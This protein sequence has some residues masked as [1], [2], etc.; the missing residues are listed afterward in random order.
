MNFLA[1][2]Y[3]SQSISFVFRLR[4][5][6]I[7]NF[8]WV[9]HCFGSLFR[10]NLYTPHYFLDV[11]CC[12]YFYSYKFM[13]ISLYSYLVGNKISKPK[14]FLIPIFNQYSSIKAWSLCR[15]QFHWWEVSLHT[16]FISWE[17]NTHSHPHIQ[18]CNHTR[19][20][21]LGEEAGGGGSK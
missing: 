9:T 20:Q 1:L 15:N 10:T 12:L 11:L 14:V 2:D 5:E 18:V 19:R 17:A 16:E 21:R 6:L 13:T 7:L 3:S 8:T 4:G